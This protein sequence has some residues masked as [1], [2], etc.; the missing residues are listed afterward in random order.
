VYNSIWDEFLSP[1]SSRGAYILFKE[2]ETGLYVLSKYANLTVCFLI[3]LGILKYIKEYKKIT[4]NMLIYIT[5]SLYF[6]WI[7]VLSV[8]LPYFAVM[9]PGRL[10]I[11][12]L[13]TLS[14]FCVIGATN[15]L[16][17]IYATLKIKRI[18]IEKDALRFMSIYVSILILFNTGLFI[19]GIMHD[20]FYSIILNKNSINTLTIEDKAKFYSRYIMEYDIYSIRWLSS[21]CKE[22]TKVYYTAGYTSIASLPH[23]YGS[24]HL[25]YLDINR[26]SK[27]LPNNS[28]VWLLYANTK[29]NIGFGVIRGVYLFDW[30]EF[31][32]SEIYQFITNSTNKIYTNGGSQVLWVS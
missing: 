19:K 2:Y 9:G 29:E 14:L 1:Q 8:V 18:S 30:Y 3:I 12:G 24:I 4:N 15:L 7:L 21:Y 22:D 27:S 20:S 25:K 31:N 32:R 23:N 16:Q 26:N 28:Y 6:L 5:L 11:L 17:I 10:Y 13:V